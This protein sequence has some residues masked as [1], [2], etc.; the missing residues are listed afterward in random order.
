VGQ[1]ENLEENV[2]R[3]Y[4]FVQTGKIKAGRVN[5]IIHSYVEFTRG[6]RKCIMNKNWQQKG[7]H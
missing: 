2:L 6:I 5:S 7:E 1:L 3:G 4:F